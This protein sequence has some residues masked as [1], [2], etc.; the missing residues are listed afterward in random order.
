LKLHPQLQILEETKIRK[1]RNL[2]GKIGKAVLEMLP[3]NEDTMGSIRRLL[4]LEELSTHLGSSEMGRM[5]YDYS[6]GIDY[7]PVKQTK[8]ALTKSITAFKSFSVRS[9]ED[10]TKWITLLATDMLLRVDV[11]SSRNNRFPTTCTVQFYVRGQNGEHILQPLVAV[12]H[13][14]VCSFINHI[15]VLISSFTK[16]E[17]KSKRKECQNT[18]SKQHREWQLKM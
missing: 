2:G 9:R 3:E 17:K 14:C 11:D 4:T 12:V 8:G 1:T 5:V 18:V 16:R 6:N 13:I 15:C 10:V 7:E